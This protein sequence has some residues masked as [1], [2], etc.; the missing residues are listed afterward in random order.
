VEETS[1]CLE[2]RS[3]GAWA[4]VVAEHKRSPKTAAELAGATLRKF[5]ESGF[6]DSFVTAYRGHPQLLPLLSRDEELLPTIHRI[7]SSAKDHALAKAIG[8]SIPT[9]DLYRGRLSRR[10][11]EVHRLMASGMS[12]REIAQTL[13]ISE[14]TVKVHVRRVLKKLG[15]RSRTEAALQHNNV[16]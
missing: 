12:N 15:V 10:E 11:G 6:R 16:D 3:L 4:R 2:G 9:A 13:F 14:A 7:L 5:G 8:L 1:K